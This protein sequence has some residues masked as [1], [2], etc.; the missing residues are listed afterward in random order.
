MGVIL[1]AAKF[2][3]DLSFI[4]L[5]TVKVN[6]KNRT[7]KSPLVSLIL[8]NYDLHNSPVTLYSSLR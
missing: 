4:L 6:R 5:R 2:T 8:K 7:R 3:E 1:E